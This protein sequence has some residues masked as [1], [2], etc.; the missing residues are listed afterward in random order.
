MICF[1][2]GD[3]AKPSQMAFSLAEVSLQKRLD[4]IPRGFWTNNATTQTEDVHVVILDSLS[5]GKM[6]HYQSRSCTV[7]FVCSD[8]RSHTTTTN[9][10]SAIQLTCCNRPC[11]RDYK[12]RIIVAC[13]QT[14]STEVDDFMACFLETDQQIFL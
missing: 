5:S 9:R 4:Q 12:I 14:V 8:R 1:C 11:K 3:F 10:Y 6:V 2:L 7:N 13:F